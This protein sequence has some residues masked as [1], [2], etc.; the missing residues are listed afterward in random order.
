MSEIKHKEEKEET[1]KINIGKLKKIPTH[2]WA[3]ATYVFGIAFI[4]LLALMISGGY[5]PNS[6]GQT[7]MK[8]LSEDFINT[9]LIQGGGVQVISLT[10]E[11]GIYVAT[12]LSQG[13][14]IPVYFTKDGKFISPGRP[15]ALITDSNAPN[16]QPVSNEPVNVSVG[17]SPVIGN[18]NA[19]V[20][21]IEFSDF[22]CPFCRQFY[23][24][25][26]NQ[27]KAQYIDT[28]KV[29]LVFKNFPL[30]NLH[31]SAEISAEAVL[32]VKE[33]GGDTAFFKMHD[34]IFQEQNKLDGGNAL[35]GP[36]TKTITYTSDDL[37]KWAKDLSYDISSCLDSGKY[38]DQVSAEESEG[39]SIGVTGT[40]SFV[41]NGQILEGAQPLSAFQTVIEAELN[42]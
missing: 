41:I 42:K 20:T 23:S 12:I 22:Q 13:Q 8:S 5:S 4:I 36:V 1:I 27:L 15:L 16:T 26:Y 14:E 38:K 37:K 32:C 3:I 24:Q 28:G 9:Q 39:S 40:P 11:S 33:K 29:K 18:T 10:Q 31:P 21:I 34:K 7:K 6:I 2:K 25:T 17:N 35:T 30:I 19:P